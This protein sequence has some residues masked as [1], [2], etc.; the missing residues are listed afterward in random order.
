MVH[1]SAEHLLVMLS[2]YPDKDS[3]EY[4]RLK[5]ALEAFLKFGFFGED[6]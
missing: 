1:Y 4:T 6:D 5:E 3:G 2:H